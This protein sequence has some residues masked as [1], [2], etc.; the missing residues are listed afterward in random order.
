MESKTFMERLEI[1]KEQ[2]KTDIKVKALL[3]IETLCFEDVKIDQLKQNELIYKFAH[4]AL[5]KDTCKR[6][7]HSNWEKELDKWYN[8]LVNLGLL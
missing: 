8:D 6:C 4:C 3:V 5:S 2:A 1:N 7:N